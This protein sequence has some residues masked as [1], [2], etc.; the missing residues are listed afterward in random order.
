M[1]ALSLLLCAATLVSPDP[2]TELQALL[3]EKA[4]RLADYEVRKYSAALS[5][6]T[7]NAARLVE[8][9]V[10]RLKENNGPVAPRPAPEQPWWMP[11]HEALLQQIRASGGKIDIVFLGDSNS[12]GWDGW[13]E[14]EGN[15]HN[16]LAEIRRRH[17]VLVA[18]F[19]GDRTYHAIWRAQNGE[20]DGYEA[21]VITVLVGCNNW[22]ENTPEEIAA[23]IRRLVSICREKQPKAKI[24]LMPL[25]PRAEEWFPNLV[26]DPENRFKDL[27]NDDVNRLIADI[28]DGKQVV[29]F[30]LRP[31]LKGAPKHLMPDRLH[32]NHDGYRIWWERMRPYLEPVPDY[33]YREIRVTGE[34]FEMVPLREFVYPD[35]RFP[36]TD[37][38]AKPDGTKCTEAI[39][40]A[41]A[42]CNAAG[43]GYVVVP[44]GT[45]LTGKVHFRSNVN[46]RLEEGATLEFSDEKADYLPAVHTTWEGVECWNTSPLVY[47]Y[48]CENVAIT[49]P[50]TLA[51]RTDGWFARAE[52]KKGTPEHA[53]KGPVMREAWLTQYMWGS[54][55]AA[56][57]ARRLLE[58]CPKAEL[59][60]QFVQMNRCRNVLLDGFRIRKSPFWCIHLY[61]S[62][63]V[64]ARNL[65]LKANQH[66]NDAFD[67]D[68][69][70]N[71]LVENCTL[72]NSDDG[73]CM[74]A[75]RNQ[76]AWRL[77][78]PTENVVVRNCHVKFAHTL[79]GLGSEL[80]GGL[81]NISLHDCTTDEA[82]NFC[83]LKTNCRRGGFV[84][85]VHLRNVSAAK[86]FKMFTIDT[87]VM[88]QYRDFPTI[89]VHPTEIDG[90]HLAN[91]S[92]DEL[93]KGIEVRGDKTKKVRNLTFRDVRIGKVCETVKVGTWEYGLEPGEV[94]QPID[95]RDAEAVR[96]ENVTVE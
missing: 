40:R 4:P 31:F 61:L 39:A 35:Q 48:E 83:F 59:R 8:W 24:L 64:I 29:W 3:R 23:D 91:V 22:A 41:M 70:R 7:T 28:P 13:Y 58:A 80:S 33:A 47:A 55:N 57:A 82:Y 92:C 81:R 27:K 32:L 79:L 15:G 34:P 20:L 87:D 36:I 46:L 66:N 56:L 72:D 45:W 86:A 53:A 74:K 84:K 1:S 11:R 18:G 77:N 51:A 19:G 30:D 2:R 94:R 75:G 49:G 63:N 5:D 62:E 25:F 26:L 93:L 6:T 95:I 14:G 67:I 10:A 54:T 85:N 76:D 42:A 73:F 52:P 65:D 50:G 17:S 43:G 90:I 78:T 9:A 37:F 38:G 69:T 60:P 96:L 16:V 44:K 89:E 88:Y 12:H 68:M 71:V 21:K